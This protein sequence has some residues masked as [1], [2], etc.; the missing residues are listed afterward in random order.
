MAERPFTLC[1]VWLTL[2]DVGLLTSGPTDSVSRETVNDDRRYTVRHLTSTNWLL[3]CVWF[4]LIQNCVQIE[5]SIVLC[6]SGEYV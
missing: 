3:L 2:R 1:A 6:E 5:F 4:L